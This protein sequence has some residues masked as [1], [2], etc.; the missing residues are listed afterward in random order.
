MQRMSLRNL[1]NLQD[2]R[3]FWNWSVLWNHPILGN[4]LD[5]MLQNFVRHLTTLPAHM[6]NAMNFANSWSCRFCQV[7]LGCPMPPHKPVWSQ[8]QHDIAHGSPGGFHLSSYLLSSRYLSF[9]LAQSLQC[10]P[11][12]QE[13]SWFAPTKGF[14]DQSLN[15]F[16]HATPIIQTLWLGARYSGPFGWAL[17]NL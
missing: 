17:S 2:C 12:W 13:S 7:A 4:A 6:I 9:Y 5:C 14:C 11:V 8:T 16:P 3:W 1:G 15:A 10:M